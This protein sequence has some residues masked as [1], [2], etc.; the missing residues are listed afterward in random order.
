MF[1]TLAFFCSCSSLIKTSFAGK[2]PIC[3]QN[4]LEQFPNIYICTYNPCQN[5]AGHYFTSNP[6]SL[7]FWKASVIPRILLNKAEVHEQ[8]KNVEVNTK[9]QNIFVTSL[10]TLR[11][12]ICNVQNALA[13][14]VVCK[15]VFRYAQSRIC[16]NALHDLLLGKLT[17][18]K[19]SLSISSSFPEKENFALLLPRLTTIPN[20]S[21]SRLKIFHIF[22]YG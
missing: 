3:Q 4:T 20:I 21:K 8:W 5:V 9:S 14:I 10:S 1:G 17:T 12:K 19:R 11:T 15:R 2:L 13:R 6:F 22:L 18:A 16:K 7:I